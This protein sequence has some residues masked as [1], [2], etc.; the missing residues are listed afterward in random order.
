MNVVD[1]SPTSCSGRQPSM[2][3]MLSSTQVITPAL[4]R[5]ICTTPGSG[6]RGAPAP[7]A[8]VSA[9]CSGGF[10]VTAEPALLAAAEGTGGD[11]PPAPFFTTASTLR[12]TTNRADQG[13]SQQL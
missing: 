11:L 12:A 1:G 2:S 4:S 13:L 6:G 8:V 7:V 5:V 3:Q 10:D 9:A